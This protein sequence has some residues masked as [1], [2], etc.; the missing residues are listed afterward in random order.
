MDQQKTE[1]M[2]GKDVPRFGNEAGLTDMLIDSSKN[3]VQRQHNNQS[4]AGEENGREKTSG[5]MQQ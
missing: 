4:E 2:L 1:Q 5:S 3:V